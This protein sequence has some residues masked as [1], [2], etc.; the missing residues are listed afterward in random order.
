MALKYYASIRIDVRK[1][2][3]IEGKKDGPAIGVKIKAKVAKNKVGP[4]G[5]IASFD[6]I[7][8]KGIDR[9]GSLLDAAE[10]TSIVERKGAYY[11]YGMEGEKVTLGQGRDKAIAFLEA[12]ENS[13]VLQSLEAA[14]KEKLQTNQPVFVQDTGND[15]DQDSGAEMG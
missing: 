6:L 3:F 12:G 11:Y 9:L 5:G 14:T 7:Y 2:K 8:S 4:P 1:Q 10:N 13:K 15:V